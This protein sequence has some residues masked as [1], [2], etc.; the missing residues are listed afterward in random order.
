M[1]TS[2]KFG[3]NKSWRKESENEPTNGL[4]GAI[5][6]LES[7]KLSKI[8]RSAPNIQL[9]AEYHRI[10]KNDQKSVCYPIIEALV[11]LSWRGSIISVPRAIVPN[12]GKYGFTLFSID[13]TGSPRVPVPVYKHTAIAFLDW[14]HLKDPKCKFSKSSWAILKALQFPGESTP[15]VTIYD[16]RKEFLN[17]RGVNIPRSSLEY[18]ESYRSIPVFE[19]DSMHWYYEELL[20]RFGVFLRLGKPLS[21]NNLTKYYQYM[22]MKLGDFHTMYSFDPASNVIEYDEFLPDKK[23][24]LLTIR[25]QIEESVADMHS[26]IQSVKHPMPTIAEQVSKESTNTKIDNRFPFIEESL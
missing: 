23:D 12:V 24:T 21:A 7:D 8:Q 9:R 19:V 15:R 22:S 4:F 13:E 18:R 2:N 14:V 10:H 16:I 25:E 1:T 26:S 5:N 11:V 17:G 6:S 20:R 3:F